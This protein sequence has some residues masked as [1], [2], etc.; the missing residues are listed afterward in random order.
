MSKIRPEDR[1]MPCVTSGTQKWNGAIPSFI[2][3]AIVMSMEAIGL[4]SFITVHW[5]ENMKLMIMAIINS[6]EDVDWGRKYLVDASVARGLCFYIIRGIRESRI[7]LNQIQKSNKRWLI[8]TIKVASKTV[9]RR[10][11][12]I[13][14][15]I[16]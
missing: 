12:R 16:S 4:N 5:P 11:M 7:I 9:I 1:G 2:A 13:I 6:I 15:D 14:G 8:I 3:R 10:I